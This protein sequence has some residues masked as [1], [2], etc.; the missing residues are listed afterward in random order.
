[1]PDNVVTLPPPR[2]H[3]RLVERP[4]APTKVAPTPG[5]RLRERLSGL[6]S[7]DR[8]RVTAMAKLGPSLMAWVSDAIDMVDIDFA[9]EQLAAALQ[10]VREQKHRTPQ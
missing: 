9:E 2:T 1:M 5:Q 6:I 3:L 7:P 10:A 8:L 4:A